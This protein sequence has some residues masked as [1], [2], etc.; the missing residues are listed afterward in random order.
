M[1][2]TVSCTINNDN[3]IGGYGRYLGRIGGDN[4]SGFDPIEVLSELPVTGRH[5]LQ[6]LKDFFDSLFGANKEVEGKCQIK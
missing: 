4:S 5:P 6:P 1:E 3:F 2:A